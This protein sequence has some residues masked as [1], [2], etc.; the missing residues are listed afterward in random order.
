MKFN[1]ADNLD[2]AI[3]ILQSG[4]DR[5]AQPMEQLEEKLKYYNE[6][7]KRSNDLPKS[8]HS[9]VSFPFTCYYIT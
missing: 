9:H 5:K 6:L 1:Y 7:L 4:L 2:K 8:S 3:A